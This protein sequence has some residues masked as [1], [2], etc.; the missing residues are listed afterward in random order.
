M[1]ENDWIDDCFGHVDANTWSLVS[2]LSAESG[3]RDHASMTAVD[4]QLY[5]IGGENAKSTAVADISVVPT[6]TQHILT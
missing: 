1:F 6:G 4:S 3:S 2:S 5:I